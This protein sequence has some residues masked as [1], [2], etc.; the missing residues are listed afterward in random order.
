MKIGMLIMLAFALTIANGITSRDAQATTVSGIVVEIIQYD[1]SPRIAVWSSN[2]PVHYVFGTTWA[3]C[4]KA[5]LTVSMDTIKIW[6]NM[7][8]SALLSGRKVDLEYTTKPTCENGSRAITAIRL[9][10]Q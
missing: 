3:S 5:G 9:H 10:R 8:Q 4:K 6:H 1:G 7:L 2:Q